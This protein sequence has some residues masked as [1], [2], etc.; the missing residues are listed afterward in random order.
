LRAA[1]AS[2]SAARAAMVASVMVSSQAMVYD[3]GT[4]LQCMTPRRM[5]FGF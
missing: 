2:G 1:V 5:R 4:P 3:S